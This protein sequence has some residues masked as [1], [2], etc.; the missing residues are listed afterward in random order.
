MFHQR[1]GSLHN[2]LC[3]TVIPFQ[4]EEAGIGEL[5]SEIEN[6]VN[7]RTTERVDA[8]VVVADDT[9]TAVCLRQQTDDVHLRIVRVLILVNKNILKLLSV[10]FPYL[11]VVTEEQ[12][13]VKQNIIK[14]HGI[15]LPASCLI[16]LVYQMDRRHTGVSVTFGCR[17]V[18]RILISRYQMVFRHRNE[19][20]DRRRLV[21]LLVK[22]QGFHNTLDQ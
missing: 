11:T 7:V 6:I 17:T 10:L 2:E 22:P 16:S 8:L 20:V 13:R 5:V 21:C 3:R 19:A 4:L 12:V 18:F 9:D 1:V 15:R 14:V